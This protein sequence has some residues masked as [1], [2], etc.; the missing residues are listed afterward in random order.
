MEWYEKLIGAKLINIGEELITVEKAG[1]IYEI[2]II[3]DEGMDCGHNEVDANFLADIGSKPTITN[4]LK[5]EMYNM[6]QICVIEFFEKNKTIATLNSK[7]SSD[8]DGLNGACVSLHCEA[9]NIDEIIT[10]W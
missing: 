3:Q 8:T 2:D 5:Y 6:G 4:I 10:E 9:L 1:K 7:S